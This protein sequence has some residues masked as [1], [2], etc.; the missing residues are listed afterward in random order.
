VARVSGRRPVGFRA[1][2]YALSPALLTALA[3]DG[4]RYDS[5]AF[6]ALPYYAG[7]AA[8]LAGLAAARRRSQAI[9]DRPRVLLAP[10]RPYRPRTDEPYARGDAALVELPITTGLA[11]FPLL[12]TFVGTL[13][14]WLVRALAAGTGRLPLLN[15]ELHGLDL[16]DASDVPPELAAR[17]PDVRVAAAV[18]LAR[19]EQFVRER[20]DRRWVTLEEAADAVAA[21]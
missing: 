16:L 20:M 15:L 11:G 21:V 1:P 4:Y 2:G 14:A 17:R 3:G 5:S 7:K 10:R 19:I 6:P 18:K 12:G 8:V 13:P 9:L